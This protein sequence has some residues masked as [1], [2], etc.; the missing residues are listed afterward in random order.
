[1]IQKCF[2]VATQRAK[3]AIIYPCIVLALH[4]HAE[5]PSLHAQTTREYAPTRWV[6]LWSIGGRMADTTF[7]VIREHVSGEKAVYVL[8]EGTLQVHALDPRGAR[9]LWSKGRR[10]T[11]PGEFLRPVDIALTADGL[12]VLDQGN[13][14]ITFF[15]GEGRH[16]RDVSGETLANASALCVLDDGSFVVQHSRRTGYLVRYRPDG[17]VQRKWDFPWPTNSD[18]PMLFASSVLRG[19]VSSECHFAPTFGFGL[20]HVSRNGVLRTTPLLEKYSTPGFQSQTGSNGVPRTTLVSGH[21]ASL[22]GMTWGDTIGV[23]A[24]SASGR[25]AGLDL[26]DRISGR[27]LATWRLPPDDR[28]AR[29]QQTVYSISASEIT[30]GVRAWA[31]TSD[32]TRIFRQSG[33]TSK[34]GPTTATPPASTPARPPA[35]ARAR[36]PAN[37]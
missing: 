22:G 27:Y 20:A 36:P 35:P 10:G 13:G 8:D 21:N 7:G 4:Q 16:L 19:R 12:A 26:Y 25:Y 6:M 2:T 1:M 23:Q 32:T 3:R 37:R 28:F 29:S 33:R 31:D 5:V 14:R 17:R 15:S 34:R 18:Q 24:I 30:Q 11:G 9:V